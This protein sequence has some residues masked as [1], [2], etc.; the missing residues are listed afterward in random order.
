MRIW[1]NRGFSLAPIAKAMKA[2]DNALEVLISTGEGR[3]V[4]DGADETFVEPDLDPADYVQ[5]VRTQIIARRVD[6]FIPTRLREHFYDA[7]L[8]CLVHFACSKDA[9]AVIED[10]HAFAQATQHLEC[11]LPT[12]QAETA[13][14]LERELTKFEAAYP[15]L[16]PCV[17]PR[18]GVNGHGFWKLTD[19]SPAA[20]LL[21][22]EFRNMRKDVFIQTLRMQELQEPIAPLVIM[23]YLPGPE[24][25][26]DVLA[27]AGAIL[28]Y[29]A[30][31]K[32][33]RRQLIQTRHP[34]EPYAET[35]VRQFGLHG[36]VNLQFRKACDDSW[37]ILEINAR[38]AGGSVYAE[39]FGS[40]LLGD[41]GGI[42]TGRLRPHEVTAPAI[43]LE[44]R[45]TTVHSIVDM[46]EHS[47]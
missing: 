40:K 26:F 36:V 24:V 1:F 19:H 16:Q 22:P 46:K 41:W 34:L 20:H 29:V 44:I 21:H 6:I 42:L 9:Y 14:E 30:R 28:N 23:G 33:D 27:H 4:Y 15:G 3:P 8:P 25:S 11:H 10:K 31:T 12:L 35:L 43:D 5:W 13:D 47:S 32:F 18:K 39:E 7:D 2:A 45:K 17:K 38:P 37:K